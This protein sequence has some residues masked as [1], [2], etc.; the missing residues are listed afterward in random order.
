[1]EKE[2]KEVA[3]LQRKRLKNVIDPM[4]SLIAIDS[5]GYLNHLTKTLND[6]GQ[7]H[8]DGNV[9]LNNIPWIAVSC[10]PLSYLT[11]SIAIP[12]YFFMGSISYLLYR[13]LIKKDCLFCRPN[14]MDLDQVSMTGEP[15]GLT[16]NE[17]NIRRQ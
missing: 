13:E 15:S 14:L 2:I 8:R 6:H 3:D 9:L 10:V 7:Y 17:L 5:S 1:M 12:M 4:Q 16:I 11:K